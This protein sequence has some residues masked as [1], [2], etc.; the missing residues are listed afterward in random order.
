MNKEKRMAILSNV[1]NLEAQLPIPAADEITLK[2]HGVL[3]LLTVGILVCVLHVLI[4]PGLTT[5]S[6]R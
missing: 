4:V 6:T 2:K 5:E 3:K 1:K